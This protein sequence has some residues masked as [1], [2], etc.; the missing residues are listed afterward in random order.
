MHGGEADQSDV[1][2]AF[3]AGSVFD[4][5]VFVRDLCLSETL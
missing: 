1:L 3:G 5:A 2:E 4:P